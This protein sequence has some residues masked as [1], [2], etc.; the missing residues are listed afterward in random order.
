MTRPTRRPPTRP[1]SH[2]TGGRGGARKP[3]PRPAAV[4]GASQR[5]VR[6]LLWLATPFALV[7]L[8]LLVLTAAPELQARHQWLAEAASFAPY[9]WL[10]WL[11]AVVLALTGA[12]GRTRFLAA[13]LAL[14]LAWHTAVLV[15]YLPGPTHAAAAG[16]TSLTVVELNL[17][18]G[19]ANLDQLASAIAHQRPDVVV[20]A[21]VTRSDVAAFR[22]K[23]WSKLLPYRSGTAGDN[24]DPATAVGDAR[25]T[26]VLS[27]HPITPLDDADGTLFSN[28]AVR[29]DLPG[30]PITL[31][32]AHPANPEHGLDR[33]VEDGESLTRLA[34]KHTD[35]PLVLAGD[36]NAT[37]EHLTLRELTAKAGLTDAG[38]GEGWHPTFPADTW[39]PPLIQ[40]DH[41][42]VSRGFSTTAY[43]TFRVDGTDHLGLQVRL[44]F[45]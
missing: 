37:A 18:W 42:L 24:Y 20:L 1:A 28:L 38:S 21:E 30:H 45:G 16:T 11:V 13:P 43:R 4:A 36:L 8:G 17:R 2:P 9:G 33:W 32:A 10:A 39:Y 5:S 40:I 22:R 15:P 3:R 14:G 26:M 6:A 29:I 25:G 7:G 41:V 44:A 12:R 27:P 23:P 35:G 34:L 19:Q 31:I